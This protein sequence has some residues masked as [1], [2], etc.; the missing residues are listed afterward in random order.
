M[1]LVNVM[2]GGSSTEAQF[3]LDVGTYHPKVERLLREKVVKDPGEP[4][5]TVRST[6][7]LSKGHNPSWELMSGE[8]A[9]IGSIVTTALEE[10]IMP[11]LELTTD[12]TA[13]SV[14]CDKKKPPFWMPNM[15]APSAIALALGK[16]AL[17]QKRIA[18]TVASI[19]KHRKERNFV[20]DT[21]G[22][23]VL[24]LA[25]QLSPSWPGPAR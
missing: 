6:F 9:G 25:K 16:P 10:R 19:E 15:L 24:K 1:V 3:R 18:A 22:I 4:A 21:F 8:E 5:C 14:A 23:D 11:W 12:M 17:A 20:E 2:R 7:G 13:L